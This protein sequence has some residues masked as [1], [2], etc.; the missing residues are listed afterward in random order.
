M[1]EKRKIE[2]D[3]KPRGG[4]IYAIGE[5]SALAFQAAH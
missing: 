2:V 4:S 3:F 1:V 5:P